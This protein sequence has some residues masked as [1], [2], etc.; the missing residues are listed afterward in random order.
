RAELPARLTE[1]LAPIAEGV[2]EYIERRRA[3]V[4]VRASEER[5]RTLT[6]AI[7]QI[8]WNAGPDGAMT[9]FNRRW[10]DYTGVPL[11]EAAGRGW[12]AAVH[13]DD[14]G[15]IDSAW[16]ETVAP[17]ADGTADRF[18]HEVRLRGG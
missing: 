2:A 18:S 14:R 1:E 9:Y 13:P 10:L 11:D 8:V 12:L 16:R 15:R 4:A 5:Y 17:P 6:E 3:E 7:P